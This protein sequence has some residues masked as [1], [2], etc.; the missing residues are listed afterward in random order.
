MASLNA[1][2]YQQYLFVFTSLYSISTVDEVDAVA[3][4]LFASSCSLFSIS[5]TRFSTGEVTGV[6]RMRTHVGSQSSETGEVQTHIRVYYVIYNDTFTYLI[7][8][9]T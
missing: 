7:S 4:D 9:G 5:H 3:Y 1:Y 6:R 8:Y 2:R